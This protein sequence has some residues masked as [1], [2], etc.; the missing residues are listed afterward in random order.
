[1][2]RTKLGIKQEFFSFAITPKTEHDRQVVEQLRAKRA[3]N[4]FTRWILDLINQALENE[5][6]DRPAR[7]KSSYASIS[8]RHVSSTPAVTIA[9]DTHYE[10]VDE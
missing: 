6:N 8:P 4:D 2:P 1:M 9:D 5:Q 7:P 3:A 10:P